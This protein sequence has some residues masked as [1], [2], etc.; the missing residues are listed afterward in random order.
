[1]AVFSLGL[2]LLGGLAGATLVGVY[3]VVSDLLFGWH[4]NEIFAA[5]SIVDYRSFLRMHIAQSG[6]LTILP[7]G[8]RK[9]PLK[10]RLQL[11]RK[12]SD[13]FYEPADE[14][15]APHLIEGPIIIRPR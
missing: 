7:I 2:V 6:K 8:L 11:D 12:N 15:L 14:V 10:W 3:F 9:V 4:S 13:P 1:V 5:Q